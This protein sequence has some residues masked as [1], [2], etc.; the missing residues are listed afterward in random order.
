MGFF[1]ANNTPDLANFPQ[2]VHYQ[3]NA[4][5]TTNTLLD[6]T[7]LTPVAISIDPFFFHISWDEEKE[8]EEEEREHEFEGG[9]LRVKGLKYEKLEISG[10]D[11]NLGED[12]DQRH[13]R[14]RDRLRHVAERLLGDED[15]DRD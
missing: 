4:D 2:G 5:F 14:L 12:D 15:D 13:R 1:C 10:M 9:Q 3:R 7:G 8:E 11:L 6:V